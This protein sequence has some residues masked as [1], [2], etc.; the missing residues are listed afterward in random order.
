MAAEVPVRALADAVGPTAAQRRGAES[1]QYARNGTALD[2]MGCRVFW[3]L[4]HARLRLAIAE[5]DIGW[6]QE[7]LVGGNVA[8][9]VALMMLDAIMED[10]AGVR[11]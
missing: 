3:E 5:S 4:R 8:P 9:D 6:A 2:A 1:E 10:V 7:L 11:P